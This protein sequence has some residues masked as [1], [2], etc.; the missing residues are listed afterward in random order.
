MCFMF[1]LSG[2]AVGEGRK[3]RLYK[4]GF[5]RYASQGARAHDSCKDF[6][7]L[8]IVSLLEMVAVHSR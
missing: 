2:R 3:V 1:T 6:A 7:Q 4:S 5:C 8:V